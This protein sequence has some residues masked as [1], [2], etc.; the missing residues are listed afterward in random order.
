VKSSGDWMQRLIIDV[1][2]KMHLR[3][4]GRFGITAGFPG[5]RR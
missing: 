4:H 3:G 2:S 1:R 5:P